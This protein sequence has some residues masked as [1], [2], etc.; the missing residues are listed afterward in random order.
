MI[1]KTYELINLKKLENNVR[2]IVNSSTNYKYNIAVVK[3]N[4]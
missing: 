2:T 1:R 3:A 4:C